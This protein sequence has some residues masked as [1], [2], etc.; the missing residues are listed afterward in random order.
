MR[1]GTVSLAIA[2]AVWLPMVHLCF[3]SDEAGKKETGVSPIAQQLAARHLHLW[4]DAEAREEELE[5]MR[6]SNAEWDF[7]GRSY[8]VWALGNMCLREPQRKD[9]YLAVMDRIIDETLATEREKGMHHFL[10]PYA[11]NGPFV[12]Q[13][14]RSQF[15]DG[16]I[17]L[18]LAV[19]RLVEEKEA[20]RQPLRQRVELIVRR[21]KQSPVLCA[22]SYPNECW[23]FCNTVALAAVRISDHLDGTDH[24]AFF[25]RW[26]KTA[27]KRLIDRDTGLLVSSFTLDGQV[28][29]GPEGSSIWMAAHC[30]QLI[31]EEF[32]ADQYRRARQELG[33]EICG[34]GYAR[35]WPAA[36]QGPM[37]V[38]SGPV[39][40]GLGVSAGSS[41]LAFVGAATFD[42]RKYFRALRTTLD[43][44][45][46]PLEE[47]GRLRYGASNQVGDAV[48]LYATVLGPAWDAVKK[49]ERYD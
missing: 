31:D 42:D 46:F 10:M 40:P 41:G 19:R 45:G 24:S 12:V 9:E 28:L 36:W 18:M 5:R 1:L 6:Q 16:E 34:F 29:D 27:R 37:D 7:M 30:L 43:F 33:R 22:E 26:V 3:R 4:T 8:L 49:G 13:P 21:M 35:E 17:A 15:I 11:H 44:A 39:V 2:A 20:Y 47:E 48:L 25:R 14:P 23:M 38:D 32:A